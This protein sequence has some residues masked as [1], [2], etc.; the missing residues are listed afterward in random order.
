ML[1]RLRVDGLNQSQQVAQHFRLTFHTP[2]GAGML[3]HKVYCPLRAVSG[4][5]EVNRG[6][7]PKPHHIKKP[8]VERALLFLEYFSEHAYLHIICK[9]KGEIEFNKLYFL[10]EQSSVFPF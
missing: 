10:R 3:D 5:A 2:S 6:G 8:W 9:A 7:S 4:R 1:S